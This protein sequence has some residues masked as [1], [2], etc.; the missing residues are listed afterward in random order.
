VDGG[1]MSNKKCT[2][3]QDI[4]FEIIDKYKL[5]KYSGLAKFLNMDY[6]TMMKW[7]VRNSIGNTAVFLDKCPGISLDCLEKSEGVLFPD[8]MGEKSEPYEASNKSAGLLRTPTRMLIEELLDQESEDDLKEL[9]R[10]QS[11]RP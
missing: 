5:N 8:A 10:I 6:H 4:F 1:Q 7:K 9:V 3:V 2:D 11:H